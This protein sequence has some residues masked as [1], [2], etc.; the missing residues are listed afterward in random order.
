MGDL[1]QTPKKKLQVP[2]RGIGLEEVIKGGLGDEWS[3]RHLVFDEVGYLK[4]RYLS[5]DE[6]LHCD[7]VGG[8]HY[9]RHVAPTGDGLVG[10][11]EASEGVGIGIFKGELRVL[12]K[13]EAGQMAL[14]TLRKG[15]GILDGGFHGGDTQLGL[16]TA[17]DILHHGVNHRLGVNQHLYAFGRYVEKPTRFDDLQSF[18]HQ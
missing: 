16:D 10:Q 11:G 7:F 4:E 12:L 2:Y 3:C 6:L 9:A 5:F 1:L 13:T 18:V 15:K 17:V 8:I 14:D